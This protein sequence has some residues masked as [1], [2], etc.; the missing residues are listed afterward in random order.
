MREFQNTVFGEANDQ[1]AFKL[2]FGAAVG[3]G[4][5]ESLLQGKIDLSDLPVLI[6]TQNLHVALRETEARDSGIGGGRLSIVAGLRDIDGL[7]LDAGLI[8]LRE[9]GSRKREGETCPNEQGYD[10][11]ERLGGDSCGP[12]FRMALLLAAAKSTKIRSYVIRRVS[13]LQ[14]SLHL[15]K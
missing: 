5:A 1:A 3:G 12:P 15:P 11:R 9:S 2:N 6:G 13:Q 10:E 14:G 8:F 4:E 7:G